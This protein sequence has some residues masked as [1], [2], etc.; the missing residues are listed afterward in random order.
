MEEKET[1]L[2]LSNTTNTEPKNKST[3]IVLSNQN[4]LSLSGI[5]KV[6]QST[7]NIISVIMN[8]QNLDIT[9][10]KLTVTKLDVENGVLEANGNVVSLKFAGHKQKENFFK[11][12]FG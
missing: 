11:R 5:S 7:E 4:I 9:G 3:K 12:I 10:Y 8:G 2:K 6:I 1:N